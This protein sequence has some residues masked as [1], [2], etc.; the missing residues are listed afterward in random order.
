MSSALKRNAVIVFGLAVLF[1]WSFMFAKHD[2]ALRGIIPFGEDPYDA[3]GSF[4]FIVV[5]LIALVS[6][7]RAFWPYRNG[8]PSRAQLVYLV[9]SQMAIVF[10]ALVTLASDAVAMA[11]HPSTWSAAASRNELIVLLGGMAVVAGAALWLALGSQEGLPTRG[12]HRWQWTAVALLAVVVLA[13]YPEQLVGNTIFHLV[14]VVV[15][16][17]VLFAPMRALLLAFVPYDEQLSE[18]P[19]RWFARLRWGLALLLGIA[20]GVFA[21][22]GEMS[23]GS[24]GMPLRRLLFVASVFIGLGSAGILVA[25]AFLGKPLGLGLGGARGLPAS[26]PNHVNSAHAPSQ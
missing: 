26:P 6:L 24:S 5:P 7:V 18:M 13:F 12:S 25:Y 15:G 9:R 11:R 3:V 17:A 21:F 8:E 10:A 4:A 20:V 23:E 22:A 1:D 2:P 16:A 19:A 14:T